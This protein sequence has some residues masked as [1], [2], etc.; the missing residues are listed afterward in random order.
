[1]WLMGM[2]MGIVTKS[3]VKSQ[4]QFVVGC[5]GREGYRQDEALEGNFTLT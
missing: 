2:E 3:D 5:S 4:V 1:M